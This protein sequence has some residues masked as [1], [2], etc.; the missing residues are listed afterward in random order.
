MNGFGPFLAPF[1][2]FKLYWAAW[3]LLLGV[4]AVLF[5]VRGR[6]PGVRRRFA[7]ARARLRGPAAR[8]AG[9][10]AALILALGGF[11]FYNTNVLNE[12]RARDEA[13]RPQAEYERRYGRFEDAPQPVDHR[14]GAAR[15]DLSRRAGR[16]HA[17]H[18]SAGEPHRRGDRLGARR[19]RS[20]R[21]RAL[22]LVRPRGQ[23]GARGRGNRLPDLRARAAARS[24]ATRCGSR[25]TWRSGRA[26]FRTAGSRPTWSATAPTSTGAGC[27]SSATSRVRAVRRRR[28]GS[29][30]VS[31]RGR[32][33]PDPT[34][35]RRRRSDGLVR[36]EDRVHVEAVVGTAADQIA[37]SSGVLRRSWTEN[38][39]RYFHYG[40]TSRTRS[41]RRS[42]PAQYAV[43]E[44]R[45][46]MMSRC[47]SSITRPTPPTWTG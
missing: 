31:R 25:S 32:R 4:V 18:V 38:G 35:P 34:M 36:N 29:A 22:D 41:P 42:S 19:H 8:T 21:R 44:D 27:R 20:G 23:A 28:R 15:G 9:V 46:R 37:V 47:R 43:R 17:R 7:Q 14:G 1:V 3:A 11:V 5:W 2:W 24:P 45:C 40:P 12:Y 10:A 33:C 13:G 26:A 39:R 16:R 30:S 6:E